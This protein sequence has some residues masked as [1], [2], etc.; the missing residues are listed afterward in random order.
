[1]I[2]WEGLSITFILSFLFFFFWNVRL[3]FKIL[4]LFVF[5]VPFICYSIY[6]Y[7]L[8][9]NPELIRLVSQ[10]SLREARELVSG[11]V[12]GYILVLIA[13]TILYFVVVN[14]IR[15]KK[16]SLTF[17]LIVSI[18][19]A[20]LFWWKIFQLKK[21]FKVNSLYGIL[22]QYY[23]V[24]IFSSI[25]QSIAIKRN[26]LD[27]TK[28]FHFSTYY[29]S[30]PPGRQ[31]YVFIIGES[32]R[33][34]HWHING[35]ARNTS[36]IL[37]T[38][39]NLISFKNVFSGAY[40]TYLSVPQMITR[41]KPGSMDK[42]FKE[43][44]ILSI[45]KQMDFKTVW[46]SNQDEDYYTGSFTL[47]AQTADIHLFPDDK[48]V[49]DKRNRY[50]GKY[51]PIIDSIL[52]STKEN[53]FLVF[54]TLGSHWNY[55]ERYPVNFD[56]FQPSGKKYNIQRPN[57]G[58]KQVIINSYD[59]SVIYTDY[60]ISSLIQ[61]VDKLKS[62][63]F[64]CYLSDH[65]EDL[66]EKDK[67]KLV[68]HLYPSF[69]TLH[70]PLFIWTSKTFDSLYSDKVKYLLRN[71]D[72]VISSSDIFYT[73]IGMSNIRFIGFDS[74]LDISSPYFRSYPVYYTNDGADKTLFHYK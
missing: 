9:L 74:T 2:S 12:L 22:N 29:L 20:G 32:S 65:G 46:I 17:A 1:M 56:I 43:K 59:N 19:C 62:I 61:M 47:H 37:D 54:H 18:L 16:I 6:L 68:F 48:N 67:N 7:N 41:S 26:S 52:Y 21:D 69:Q 58:L 30:R 34:D 49:P 11:Y 8:N 71:K 4:Y 24:S 35:Y 42:Q 31:V 45:F 51:L 15:I 53:I 23:P 72:S 63:S 57:S 28:N 5:F 14:N 3:F 44:S 70:V 60:I 13:L 10:T 33:Y 73:L 50:D 39:H 27:S 55:A 64:V 66:F 25:I 40:F 36:P 38:M